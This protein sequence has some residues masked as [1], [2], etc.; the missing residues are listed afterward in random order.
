MI[1]VFDSN[2][3]IDLFKH[4]YRNRF[5]SLWEKFDLSVKEG[6]VVSVREVFNEIE[7]YND[8]LSE[9]TKS[10]RYFFQQ[11]STEELVFV[12]EIFKVAHFQSLVRKKERYQGKPV[13]DP[14]VIVKAKAHS[15]CVITQEIKKPNAAGIP[16]I[17]EYFGL[18]YSNLEG[19]MEREDWTF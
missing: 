13:A 12:A 16:N 15:G 11:P 7:G 1:Y 19:F 10:N 6:N 18:D 17:C 8:R 2:A 4:F 14:F 9:W 5:P 3:L